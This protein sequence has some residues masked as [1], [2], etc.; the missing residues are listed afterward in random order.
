MF[1]RPTVIAIDDDPAILDALRYIVRDLNLNYEPHLSAESFW[2][3]FDPTKVGCIILDMGMPDQSG[4]ELFDQLVSMGNSW[5]T[6]AITGHGELALGVR[7]AKKGVLDFLEKP[8]SAEGIKSLMLQAIEQDRKQKS[9]HLH[10]VE[11]RQSVDSLNQGQKAVLNE[12]LRGSTSREIA[13]RLDIS[14]RTVQIRRTEI[15]K[16]LNI[17]GRSGWTKLVFDL[18][19]LYGNEPSITG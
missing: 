10:E 1:P 14:L 13:Q 6:I 8:F 16:I 18:R 7:M 17:V 3:S 11:I 5:P 9:K 12:I 2:R 4:E 15:A 19:Q